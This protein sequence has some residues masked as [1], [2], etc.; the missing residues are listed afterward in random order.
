M[1]AAILVFSFLAKR[2][3][4]A[5]LYHFESDRRPLFRLSGPV[6][7]SQSRGPAET[8]PL[9]RPAMSVHKFSRY[10]FSLKQ[11]ASTQSE[12]PGERAPFSP[13]IHI[14]ELPAKAGRFLCD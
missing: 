9:C 4:V 10:F 12:P 1:L 6:S 5:K 14:K 13:V 2:I 3:E 11:T 7:A 8:S